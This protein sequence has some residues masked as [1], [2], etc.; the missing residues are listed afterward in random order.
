MN[1]FHFLSLISLIAFST[2]SAGFDLESNTAFRF[3]YIG[4]KGSA[5]AARDRHTKTSSTS[6]VTTDEGMLGGSGSVYS[7]I[8]GKFYRF[9]LGPEGE[10]LWGNVDYTSKNS[11]GEYTDS[12]LTLAAILR[13]KFGFF[14]AKP[15]LLYLHSGYN[16]QR[17]KKD[18]YTVGN[19][20]EY[21]LR[22]W[23]SGPICGIGSDLFITNYLGVTLEYT[24]SWFGKERLDFINPSSLISETIQ[25]KVRLSTFSLGMFYNF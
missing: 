13:A 16:W 17:M 15:A 19:I 25:E 10:F 4:L 9:Y 5:S 6:S 23:L 24:F 21:S 3:P 1:R 11:N 14:V 22:K 20:F 18:H 8:G 12:K 2:L 7:G